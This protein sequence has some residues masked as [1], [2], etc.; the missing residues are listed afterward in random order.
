MQR[1]RLKVNM[2]INGIFFKNGTE[3]DQEKL[4]MHFRKRQYIEQAENRTVPPPLPIGSSKRK[5]A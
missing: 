3:L 2:V 5:H 1:V 4:P